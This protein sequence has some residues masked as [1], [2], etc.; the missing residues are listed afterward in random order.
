MKK[1]NIDWVKLYLEIIDVI[2]NNKSKIHNLEYKQRTHDLTKYTFIEIIQL[3]RELACYHRKILKSLDSENIDNYKNKEEIPEFYLSDNSEDIAWPFERLTRQCPVQ[4]KLND[5][6][7]KNIKITIW[8]VCLATGVNC[9]EGVHEHIE[10]LCYDD[11]LT[12]RCECK[13]VKHINEQISDLE[14]Q[15]QL[16]ECQVLDTTWTVQKN[17]KKTDKDPKSLILSRKSNIISSFLYSSF[18]KS[19]I[20]LDI[21]SIDSFNNVTTCLPLHFS[22]LLIACSKASRFYNIS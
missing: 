13:T 5:C 6:L 8:D 12:G 16:L 3:W 7:E 1:N 11:F 4:T 2:Q 19:L 14:K 21:V 15:I 10:S 20:S 9:K 17:K 18:Y 22:A